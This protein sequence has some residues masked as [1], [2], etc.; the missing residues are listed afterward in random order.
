MGGLCFLSR[1][2][3][4]QNTDAMKYKI[5]RNAIKCDNCGDVIESKHVHDFVTCRCEAVSVDGGHDYLKRSFMPGMTWTDLTLTEKI[6]ESIN[7]ESKIEN[8]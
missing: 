8:N 7:E 6:T 3:L 1:N 5:I 2:A 4:F